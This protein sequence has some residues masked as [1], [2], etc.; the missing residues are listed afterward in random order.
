[1]RCLAFIGLSNG[2]LTMALEAPVYCRHI[3]LVRCCS[4]ILPLLSWVLGLHA[5]SRQ[6]RREIMST[7]R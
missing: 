2:G 6:S 7:E 4:I 1:M 3:D 5:Y